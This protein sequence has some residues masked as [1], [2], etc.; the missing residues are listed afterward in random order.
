[1][2]SNN[3]SNNNNKNCGRTLDSWFIEMEQQL[4]NNWNNFENIKSKWKEYIKFAEF[5]TILLTNGKDANAYVTAKV[6]EI[7]KI[8]ATQLKNSES[9]MS[10]HIRTVCE[11]AMCIY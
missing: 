10:N 6:N 2:K 8:N 1:M 7:Q 5:S 3:H 11:L 9:V 4:M